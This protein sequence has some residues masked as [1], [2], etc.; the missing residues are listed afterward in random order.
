MIIF[1]DGDNSPGSRTAGSAALSPD[2]KLFVYYCSNNTYYKSSKN[3]D[4]LQKEAGCHV[5]FIATDTMKMIQ[6]MN[7]YSIKSLKI[8]W[9]NTLLPS[10][11]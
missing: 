11:P 10:R 6:L 7:D 1:V 3:R 4:L 5:E 8:F 9:K 2:D